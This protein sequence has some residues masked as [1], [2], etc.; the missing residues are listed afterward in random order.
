[1]HGELVIPHFSNTTCGRRSLAVFGPTLS[2]SLTLTMRVPSLTL[3]QFCALLTT[4]LFFAAN[5]TLPQ[6]LRD[7]LG[8]KDCCTHTHLL[9]LLGV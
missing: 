5:E 9:N 3:T 6:R 4:V 8:C 2:N 7:S 1:V